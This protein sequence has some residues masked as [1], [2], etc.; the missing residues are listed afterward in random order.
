MGKLIFISTRRLVGNFTHTKSVIM[1][2]EISEE[3]LQKHEF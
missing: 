3:E 1:C 2:V